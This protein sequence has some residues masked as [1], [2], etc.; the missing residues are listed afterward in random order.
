MAE[1]APVEETAAAPRKPYLLILIVVSG[2]LIG[3]AAGVF[4][5]V[6][7]VVGTP[8]EAAAVEGSSETVEERA[9]SGT[10]ILYSIDNLVLNPQGTGGTRFLMVTAA[11]E[12]KDSRAAD[13]M[14]IREAEIRDALLRTFGQKTVDEL[15]DLGQREQLRQD[16][17]ATVDGIVQPGSVLRVYFPQFVIQ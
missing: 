8:A 3:G 5:V 1:E 2:I 17:R 13:Q 14:R 10:P 6:P 4:V 12:L 11:F 7:M 15:V 16:L 9:R